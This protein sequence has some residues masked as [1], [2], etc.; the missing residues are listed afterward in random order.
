MVDESLEL[1]LISA[2][3][4]VEVDCDEIPAKLYRQVHPDLLVVVHLSLVPIQE[5]LIIVVRMVV[6]LDSRVSCVLKNAWR[7]WVAR[8]VQDIEMP[9]LNPQTQSDTI[10]VVNLCVLEPYLAPNSLVSLRL[11]L[12]QLD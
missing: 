1:H 11:Q 3:S 6:K 2:S 12:V 7:V 5:M 9:V 8:I 4:L 10:P